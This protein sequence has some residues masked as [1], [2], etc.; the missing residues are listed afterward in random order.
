MNKFKAETLYNEISDYPII[1]PDKPPVYKLNRLLRINPKVS[2]KFYPKLALLYLK[3]LSASVMGGIES[4]VYRQKLKAYKPKHP[5]LFVLGHWRSGTSFLQSL[6][7]TPPNYMHYNKFQTIFPDSFLLTRH[8]LKP[9]MNFL[10]SRSKSVQSWKANGSYDFNSLDTASEIEV[11]MISKINPY[12]FHWGHVFPQQWKFY[13]DRY[14]FMDDISPKDYKNWRR[15]VQKLN[16]KVNFTQP[17]SRLIIKNPGDTARLRHILSI[18]PDAQFIFIHRNPYDVFYSNI[19]LWKHILSGLSMQDVDT[20]EIKRGIRY[21][22][23]RMHQKYFADRSLVPD[24][25]MIEIDYKTFSQQ[26]LQ[27][28]EHIYDHLN[29]PNFEGNKPH[30]ERYLA[31]LNSRKSQ[32][33]Y[34]D[35]DIELIN[36]EWKFVFEELGYDMHSTS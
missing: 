14:L 32:Y 12:S 2:T 3:T 30:L 5:P 29:L 27:T 24:H 36:R 19:K 15:S 20:A 1:P 35:E 16:K 23:R 4:T 17:N 28:V 10:F 21:I 25:Q 18:Y 8:T 6:L 11:A 13:F 34:A 31:G 22:Y 33:E 7:G 26:P 9:F